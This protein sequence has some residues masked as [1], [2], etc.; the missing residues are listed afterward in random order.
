MKVPSN[1]V[2]LV[3]AMLAV[4]VLASPWCVPV[5]RAQ[6]RP[7]HRE[8]IPNFD[9][10]TG[11]APGAAELAQ[12][13][14]GQAHLR[15][16]L[17]TAA[18]D[19][20]GLVQ[21]PK[22][23]RA[24]GGFLTGPNGEGRAVTARALQAVR[25][26][27][28]YRA[29]VGFLNEHAA[30]F[31]HDAAAL[32][33]AKINREGVTAHNGLRTVVW[34]QQV[35]GI[36]VFEAVLIANITKRGELASLASQFVPNPVASADAGT[37]NRTVLQARPPVSAAQAIVNA[38]QS[39]GD[40][41]AVAEVVADG[42]A[43]AGDGYQRFQVRGVRAFAR[44]VW[45]PLNRSTLRLS[46]EVF[47][48]KQA[49]REMFQLLVDAETGEAVVRRARTCYIS[50]A[51]YNVYTS[52]SPSPFSPGWPT[53]NAAQP[54]LTNRVLLTLPALDTTASPNG[55]IDDGNNETT[56]NNVDTFMDRD[57]N[58]QPDGPRPQGNPPRVFDFPLDLTQDPF[59]YSNAAMVQLFYRLNWYHDRLY[60]FGFTESFGNFQDN[61]FGRGGLGNDHVISYVQAGA[62]VGIANNAWFA[63]P[64]D[65]IS[66][67]TAMFIFNGPDPDRDGDLDGEVVFHEATHGLSWRLVG[68]GQGLGNLQ[69]DG[70]GEGW[71]DF[72]ALCL[73]SEAGDDPDAS[74]ASGGYATYQIF[75]IRNF[76]NYYFGI[77]HYPYTTDMT[78]N[79]LTFKDIDPTQASTH[80]GVPVSPIFG[81][82]DPAQADEVHNQ[83]EVWCTTLWDVRA[84][85][86]R[87]YGFAGNN[88]M[89]QLATDGMKLTPP[90]P[91]FLQ[92]RD[93]IILADLINNG[94]ANAA[95][96]WAG[97][98]KRGMGF[99]ATSP[100]GSTTVGVVEAYDT[101][102]LNVQGFTISGGNG[103]GVID[104]NE[105]NELRIILANFNDFP[106]TSLRVTLSTTTPGVGFGV[107]SSDYADLAPLG[108]GTNLV[109][110]TIST[111]PDFLC[112]RPI[113]LQALIKSD[114]T[115]RTNT[116][117]L[118][119]GAVGPAVRFDSATPVA[120][121]DNNPVGTNSPIV[122][123]NITSA[124][125]DVTVSVYLTH[126][127]DSDLRLELIG[128]DG[129]A[130]TLSAAH[131]G[132][133]DNYGVACSP[134]SLR[135]TFDDSA[136][137]PISAGFP[138]FLGSYRPDQQLA[139]FVGKFGTNV[140]GTWKLHVVDDVAQ[141]VGTIQCWSL[142]LSP[143]QCVDGGGT[144]PGVD[145]A[146]GLADNPDP[147]FLGSNLVYTISVTNNGPSAATNVVVNQSLPGSVVFV[148]AVA[149]Q[150][151]ATHTAG[152]VVASLGNLAFAQQ[153]T[154]TVTVTPTAP[155]TIYSSATVSSKDADTDPSNNNVTI[156]THVNPPSA[157]LAVGL[158]D[159][160]D[161]TLVGGSLTYTVAVTN[162]GPSTASGVTV[163]NVL[164][165]SVNVLSVTPSQGFATIFGN[166]VV[167]NFGS[168]TAGNRATADIRVAPTAQ[169]TIVATAT[170]S[171]L[172]ADPFP[173]NNTA[174]ATT[175]VGPAA[176]LAVTFGDFP[177]PVVV[178]SNWTYTVTVTNRG[179]N[180]ASAVVLNTTLPAG[181][182][183]VSTNTTQGT[184]SRS[185]DTVT[186]NL[187]NLAVGGGATITMVVKSASSGVF[188]ASVAA[189][190]A[191][192]DPNPANNNAAE[193]T[194]VAPPTVS[195]V[196][197]GA[198]LTTESLSPPNGTVDVG[199]TVTV[200]LRLRNAG[201]VSNTNLVATL[202]ATNG[203]T[204]PSAAQNYGVLA[205][206]GLPVGRPF[207][208]TATGT[209]GGAVVAVLQLQ[210]GPND[211]GT[212]TFTFALPDVQTFANTNA[213]VIRDSASGLPYP[214]TLTVSGVTGL[215]GR[216][217]ATLSNFNHTFPHDVSA[218]LV[219]PTGAKSLL[220][221]H[222]TDQGFYPAAPNVTLV[223]DDAAAAPLPASGTISSGTWQPSA[224][225][226]APDFVTNPP[227]AVNPPPG[228]YA[229]ALS[230][231]A[232]KNPNGTWSLY[233]MDD[234][235]G[236]AG[237]VSNGWSLTFYT[238][239]PVNRLADVGLSASATPNP[240]LVAG[241]ITYTF[242]LT[243]L[244]PDTASGVAFTNVLPAGATLLSASASQGVT[245]TNGN[246]VVCSVGSLT[247]GGSATVTV[248]ATPNAAGPLTNTASVS[249]SEN[250]LNP[251]NNTASAVTAVVLPVADVGVTK[252]GPASV[253]V[254]SNVTFTVT[255]TNHGPETA[256][257]VT[258]TDPLPAGMGFVSA[259]SSA[260]S[261]IN[262]SGTVIASL[263]HLN[264]GASATVTIVAATFSTATRTNVASVTTGSSDTNS[265]N[266]SAAAVVAVNAPSPNLVAAGAAM[267]SESY[268]P[269]NTV[270]EN[271]ETV[272]IA[273]SLQNTGTADTAN[274]VATLQATG[275]VTAPGGPQNYG[276]L[277][278]G[279]AAVARP[280][281]FT[282]T[283]G[284]GG[285][286]TATLQLQDGVNNLG[287]VSFAFNLP[288]TTAFT[289]ATTI[290]IPDHGPASP[291]PST[292]V[293]SG[294]TGLV[295]KATVSLNGLTHAFPDDV[296]VLLVGPTGQKVVVM[297][298]A[299]GGY[300]VTNLTV[301]L[302]DGAASALPDAS[303]INAGSYQ[304][305]DYE[306]GDTFPA[307]APGGAA[308]SALNAFNG[309][310]PNGT[311]ALYVVDDAAGDAGTIGQGWTLT[312]TT[313]TTVNPV[314]DLAITIA[315]SPDPVF[316]GY[317]LTYTIGVT[318]LGPSPATGVTVTDT[319]P[320][321]LTYLSGAAS[322]GTIGAV[323]NLVTANVGN[324]AGG[325]GAVL[326]IQAIPTA[327][328]GYTNAVSVTANEPD[329]NPANNTAQAGTLANVPAPAQFSDVIV[330]NGQLHATLSGEPG[331]T[332][333]VQ[334]STNLTTWTPVATN[335]LPGSGLFKF[336]DADA[337]NFGHRF[338][339][340][341][342]QI[343]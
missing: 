75:G 171:A 317:P 22:F 249:A 149:S 297:S 35:D 343:P 48:S 210:D 182:T 63:T 193:T 77:R 178:G 243:N 131:G 2:R 104:A 196:A 282:A 181:V 10:R 3:V 61:N 293:V 276:L 116:I 194:T 62:D 111:T 230:A 5:A 202:L 192:A 195:I 261:V 299:G 342:R 122:V 303:R 107:R 175:T 266:N 252:A 21:S 290:V 36:P 198:T 11:A 294:L 267:V 225:A 322:Q 218:L 155:G 331:L 109:P 265:V 242:T 216:V 296:D 60:Q 28:P 29:V 120:I 170:A 153:A 150:G 259:T 113:V 221:S 165:L 236:D 183:L 263:G 27:D 45:L 64:P 56:G 69:G 209:N 134:D 247:N 15:A 167:C 285:V 301:T 117:I 90:R 137:I 97:F 89:L 244:G 57:Y 207:T 129:T 119:T 187:G 174:T 20:D 169:G 335:T 161:P 327:G 237:G 250:D 72:Y 232:G 176:D 272:T 160:P 33:D 79:P 98:A 180:A 291:Y 248:I 330:T 219:G 201:N 52:D 40:T 142:F 66:G 18:V 32:A 318:N 81:T 147:V 86:V 226:P 54:P 288:A 199:E 58:Q 336:V 159:A 206:G 172:Q 156:D 158:A 312:L 275:G 211:L 300:A 258:V 138:P 126:T 41:V 139:K 163:T 31:G 74:Y 310:N 233:V 306:P 307:P 316:V 264:A 298:D 228:P 329:P 108:L 25:A 125:R 224:Y 240:A 123:S 166:V 144:C 222:A 164:P 337:P 112:G 295:S 105:C 339:R 95:E 140:N 12:R 186:C 44:L 220:L 6:T 214:A 118:N 204:A 231:F 179:P 102:G 43:P 235:S 338:Y 24:R 332:Y 114:Q 92:A 305:A 320:A 314:A 103:N 185:G 132:S 152:T 281:T 321:G 162:N 341:V 73:L 145:L 286:V 257:N 128:P 124:L 135:T 319:L 315:D 313:V 289:N 217:T 59:T 55:W 93:A 70:M 94:G 184:L 154:V 304:P 270:I 251:A 4:A 19:F 106:L 26:D 110:F 269:A 188:N 37:P 80:A 245:S 323:G 212:A 47:L 256:L 1:V 14:T 238:V 274:L 121:P 68:G 308:G 278:H 334:A 127:Y 279:G 42:A 239:T 30:L 151:N 177:D 333:V 143:A 136:G 309:T 223:F 262:S 82:W 241:S 271:G 255:V 38:A 280:F 65:G 340:A 273:L 287:T 100:D 84:N 168:V 277:V 87:K 46:W 133:G 234:A 51:T 302:E 13:Q 157:E 50:D 49:T 85:V 260:G 96:L 311:W 115:T 227:P 39:L 213:I 284:N 146:L 253:I 67:E 99:S 197:A 9:R 324:L 53:P 326:T 208:F 71:S 83:G 8:D 215:V 246:T 91:N 76:P 325:A 141:D 17:P 34:Q 292:I 189:A 101:P 229:A 268:V 148:S 205:G 173:A 328:G 254:G 190:A 200:Q 23:V 16:L 191:Q 283:G 203:V 130:V 88:L 7:T 78:K